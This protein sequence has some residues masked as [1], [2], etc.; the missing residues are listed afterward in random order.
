MD[1]NKQPQQHE[2]SV[3]QLSS[4]QSMEDF[5]EGKI[6]D[7][8]VEEETIRGQLQ[9]LELQLADTQS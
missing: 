6:L 3:N 2:C 8:M 4:A 9:K 7:L 1:S 5:L